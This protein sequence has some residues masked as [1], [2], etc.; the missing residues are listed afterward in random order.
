MSNNKRTNFNIADYTNNL[1]N[2]FKCIGDECKMHCCRGWKISIDKETYNLYKEK[3]PEILQNVTEQDG[4]YYFERHSEL[5]ICNFFDNDDKL[6]KIQKKHG[7]SFLSS[8]CSTYPRTKKNGL[9]YPLY[10]WL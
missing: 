4:G 6:C 8:T 7:E 3:D 10:W 2:K 9:R 1:F 5:R